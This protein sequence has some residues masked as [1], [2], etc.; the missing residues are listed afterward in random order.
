M[1]PNVVMVEGKGDFYAL[2]YFSKIVLN[3]TPI[4]HLL[5]GGGAS[6]LDPII[7][8]YMGWGSNF[9][10]LLDS[11]HEGIKQR[12]RYSEKYGLAIEDR[13]FS[14]V[15]IDGNWKG[16]GLEKLISEDERV[17]FQKVAYPDCDEYKKTHFHRSIQESLVRKKPFD[18][19]AETKSNFQKT[20]NFLEEKLKKMGELNNS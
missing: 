18:F 17:R 15:D 10:V 9:I 11:D 6:G 19:S 14:L 5:P 8:L 12:Q 16:F 2:N 20:L 4:I 1:I 3:H 7:S 13:L